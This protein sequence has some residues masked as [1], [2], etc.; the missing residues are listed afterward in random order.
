MIIPQLTAK[1]YNKPVIPKFLTTFFFP[2]VKSTI[3]P[4][5]APA[6]SPAHIAAKLNTGVPAIIPDIY[7][8]TRKTE[9][10]Q[11][12][13]SP[14]RGNENLNINIVCKYCSKEIGAS[15]TKYQIDSK[16]CNKHIQSDDKCMF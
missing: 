3:N 14:M 5:P 11:F 4:T 13:I 9:A 10:L 2:V 6:Q 15:I 16:G 8:S 7:N 1:R 12:G